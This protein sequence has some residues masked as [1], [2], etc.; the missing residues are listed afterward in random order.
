MKRTKVVT[1]ALILTL[2]IFATFFALPIV[3][4]H[5]PPQEITTWAYINVAPNPIG[6]GQTATIIFWRNQPPPTAAGAGGDRWRN[7]V[8]YITKPDGTKETLGPFTSDD[9]GS[10]YTT[11]TPDQIGTY[12]LN[13]SF[14]DQVLSQTSPTGVIG[15]YSDYINDTFLASSATT[16]LTVQQEPIPQPPSYP[17]PTEYWTR[18]IEGQNTNWYTVASNWLSSPQ[19][20]YRFQQD[21]AAPNSAHIMWTKPY[22]FGGVVGGTNTGIPGMTYYTGMNYEAK[23]QTPIIMNGRLYYERPLSNNNRGGG[24][25]C[26]DLLTGEEIWEKNITGISFGQLYDYESLN[27][28]GVVPNGY[29]WQAPGRGDP[30][31]TPYRAYDP[32]TGEWLFNE[33]NVP[34]GTTV[35]GP[36][37]EILIYQMNYAGRWLAMWNN[38]AAPELAAELGT[39]SGAYQWR[40]VGKNV[41]MSTAYSWNVTIP[42]L[43]GLSSPSTLYAIY[44][45][46]IL[47]TSSSFQTVYASGGTQNPYTMWAISL[48]PSSRGQLLW[49]QNYTVPDSITRTIFTDPGWPNVDP[50]A[51]VFVM[52]D[53]ET[54][55][56]W[57]YSIDT[58]KQLWGPTAPEI[59]SLGFYFSTGG[60]FD[61]NIIAYGNFYRGGYGGIIYCYNLTT[62][63]LV[64]TYGN[65]GVGNSSNSGL[66]TPYGRYPLGIGTAADG[67]LY[68]FSSEHSPTSPYW[69]GAKIRC[70]DAYNGT[71]L[72][73]LYGYAGVGSNNGMAVADG[74]L[75]YLNAY[76]MQLYCIGKGPSKTTVTTSPKITEWGSNVFIEGTVTDISSG[77]KQDEQAARFPNGV[78]AI[79]D[80]DQ[81][82]W[83]E[84]VYMQKPC[85][86]T[87]EGVEVVLTTL[88]PNGNTYEIGRTTTSL[89]GTYGI[90][91]DP[92]VPGL[93]RII[94]TF[95]GSDSYYGSYA[96]TYINVE[97][98]PSAAQSIEPEPTTSALATPETTASAEAPFITT[99]I[100]IIAAFAV[101]VVIG[102]VSYWTLRKRK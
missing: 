16:T 92:P 101:A 62:G 66:A 21:G 61:P 2:T 91:F 60:Q 70:I 33:T 72:W 76:D 6:V 84:Y 90:A 64:F 1:I 23:F 86:E 48:K 88:D 18:P 44:D 17:L 31:D 102:V 22:S 87:A 25:V 14:P 99:E 82:G 13:C 79:S 47:G 77:T 29:L 75:V 52:R 30:P 100:A 42:D 36:N 59:S 71:E 81:G 85:P 68:L 9:V 32:L 54:L 37:G 74:Y 34:R 45:D 7:I 4:A 15:P 5:D 65:G 20:L 38:T 49:I 67:K 40:P 89:Y 98:S 94:A 63:D 96:E 3:S 35:Y 19:I 78:P 69:K 51:R 58:G 8:L 41:N 11:Y 43:N 73:T 50:T 95:E 24:F 57:G 55:Q 26:V 39:S 12:T 28:H 97:E 80:E 46:L 53:D 10:A 56:E 83:M 27:Q 93:Y